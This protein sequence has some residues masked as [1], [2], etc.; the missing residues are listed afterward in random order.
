MACIL[1]PKCNFLHGYFKCLLI[2]ETVDMEMKVKTMRGIHTFM[3][4][5]TTQVISCNPWS[6]RLCPYPSQ[7]CTST[8]PLEKI[9]LPWKTP[10]PNKAGKKKRAKAPIRRRFKVRL[11]EQ[12][13]PINPTF[14]VNLALTVVTTMVTSTQTSAVK[15]TAT[16]ANPTPLPVT[17]YNLAQSRIQEIHNP[18]IRKI[19]GEEGSSTP[20]SDNPPKVQQPQAATTATSPQTTPWP[21]TMPTSTYLFVARA[22]WPIPPSKT[23]TPIFIKMEKAEEGTP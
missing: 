3:R 15:L 10:V 17:I 8:Y 9:S 1:K 2:I 21:N 6:P 14:P 16:T 20:N 22:T 11:I 19:Q 18:P 7:L 4:H 13:L 23:S 12:C 5:C